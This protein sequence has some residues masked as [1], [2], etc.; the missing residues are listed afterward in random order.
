MFSQDDQEDTCKEIGVL[1]RQMEMDVRMTEI[2][3]EMIEWGPLCI[4]DLFQ[5]KSLAYFNP[6][7]NTYFPFFNIFFAFMLFCVAAKIIFNFLPTKK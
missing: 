6:K 4:T 5:N 3:P 7:W 1:T 2:L